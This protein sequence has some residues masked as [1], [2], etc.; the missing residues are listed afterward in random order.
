MTQLI[1]CQEKNIIL[2]IFF[3]IWSGNDIVEQWRLGS[4]NGI[5]GRSKINRLFYF[6]ETSKATK[7]LPSARGARLQSSLIGGRRWRAVMLL[8]VR[9]DA[10][11]RPLARRSRIYWEFIPCHAAL[12]AKNCAPNGLE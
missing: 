7:I 6:G 5:L 11:Q 8:K 1:V 12:A 9:C 4:Y 2:E 3:E 10:S